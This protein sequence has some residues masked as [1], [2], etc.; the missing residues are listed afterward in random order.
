VLATLKAD[1]LT[2]EIVEAVV[3]RTIELA[4]M[5]WHVASVRLACRLPEGQPGVFDLRRQIARAPLI[6]PQP[7]LVH[8]HEHVEGART[9][10]ERREQTRQAGARSSNS[11]P[12]IPSSL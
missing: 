4:R 7:A 11:A 6:A 8:R 2:P 10:L 3:T 5:N 12:L 1:V 9:L